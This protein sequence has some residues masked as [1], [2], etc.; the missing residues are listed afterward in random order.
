M[1]R[2]A[3]LHFEYVFWNSKKS[4]RLLGLISRKN[5]INALAEEGSG[6]NM[7]FRDEQKLLKKGPGLF[8]GL[9]FV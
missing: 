2:V 8:P 7:N 6:L 4:K 5:I 1:F 3:L 9:F